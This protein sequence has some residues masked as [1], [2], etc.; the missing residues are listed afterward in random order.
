MFLD[1]W[2]TGCGNRSMNADENHANGFCGRSASF[3]YSGG[4]RPIDNPPLPKDKL[5]FLNPIHNL[6]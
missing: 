1:I 4:S 2:T 5:I 6:L 3:I